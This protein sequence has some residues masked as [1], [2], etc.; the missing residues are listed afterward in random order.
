MKRLFVILTLAFLTGGVLMA[1][2]FRPQIGM[3]SGHIVS[4]S[5]IHEDGHSATTLLVDVHGND[6]SFTLAD[7]VTVTAKDGSPSYVRALRKGNSVVIVYLIKKDGRLAT[8]VER[9]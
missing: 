1:A 7:Y 3:V 8:S 4:K 9:D 5:T 2:D 6:M